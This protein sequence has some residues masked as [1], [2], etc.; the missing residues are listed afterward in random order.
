MAFD[1]GRIA[2]I[3]LESRMSLIATLKECLS[4]GSTGVA[5]R[6]QTRLEE[7][8]R[9]GQ[10]GASLDHTTRALEEM[11]ASDELQLI[12]NLLIEHGSISDAVR[13]S[14]RTGVAIP[15]ARILAEAERQDLGNCFN[16]KVR[17]YRYAEAN[18]TIAALGTTL[19]EGGD[20]K[21]STY[22]LSRARYAFESIGQPLPTELFLEYLAKLPV[23][24][25]EQN[26]SKEVTTL[27][28]ETVTPAEIVAFADRKT[29]EDAQPFARWCYHFT[30]ADNV[31]AQERLVAD[32]T[33]CLNRDEL[34]TAGMLFRFADVPIPE[35]LLVAYVLRM[36][37]A[38]QLLKATQALE[39]LPCDTHADLWLAIGD[40]Y[41][42]K[43]DVR[44]ADGCYRAAGRELP[45]DIVQRDWEQYGD[46]LVATDTTDA[47]W[48]IRQHHAR[49]DRDRLVR[50]VTTIAERGRID[51]AKEL[52][53][54][55]PYEPAGIEW[56]AIGESC[57]AQGMDAPAHDAFLEAYRAALSSASAP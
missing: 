35:A 8:W 13:V 6:A 17:L 47:S 22:N 24:Y 44:A 26:P 36:L 14:G 32:A 4:G 12:G 40:A 1:C 43:R 50:W 28:R 37:A 55:I 23:S 46:K 31:G 39:C 27:L 20:R 56:L 30:V 29:A 18:D 41:L 5:H 57:L 3:T 2:P 7:F 45:A 53:A 34:A 15:R 25:P 21:G 52:F 49:F 33:A 10:H 42:D 48:F 11:H 54:L 16:W 9:R 51:S 19:L 38:R